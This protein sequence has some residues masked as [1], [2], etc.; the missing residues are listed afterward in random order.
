[1]AAR[2]RGKGSAQHWST[3]A[4]AL[5]LIRLVARW[6]VS[7]AELLK[8]LDV[9]ETE[10]AEPGATLSLETVLAICE[11]AR[12]LT[13]E[14]GLGFHWGLSQRATAHGYAG[15]AAM[16]A[17]SYR[18]C[19]DLAI[20][21]SPLVTTMVSLRL[22]VEG[23]LASLIVDEHSE[24]TSARDMLLISVL[25]GLRQMG[26]DLTAA[27]LKASIDFSIPEPDYYARFAKLVPRL[28]F[29]QPANRL[30]FEASALE[31]PLSMS[32]PAV[33]RLV[34][35]QCERALEAV[36]RE[37]K[38]VARVRQALLGRDGFRSLRQVAADLQVSPRRLMR[39]L[40]EERTSFVDLVDQERQRK[41]LRLLSTSRL[42]LE[43][44]AAQLGYSTVSNFVRAFHRWTGQ[45]PAAYRRKTPS[46]RRS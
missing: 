37:T 39:M 9:T 6:R 35:E 18:Q 36:G 19:I 34:S 16:S 11:R 30:V 5:Q 42:A 33:L 13:R 38:L 32:D 22:E 23:E 2:E 46:R 43:D 21:Y 45:T 25:V 27:R 3:G 8:G 12:E 24:P 31:L 44:V 15:F 1:M 26:E 40:A 4:Y 20:R 17:E 10:L 7:P 29:G 14:P 28:R 41:A